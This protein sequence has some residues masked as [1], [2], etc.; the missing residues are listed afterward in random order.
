MVHKKYKYIDTSDTHQP[1]SYTGTA[2]R[3]R[4]AWAAAGFGPARLEVAFALLYKARMAGPECMTAEVYGV[5]V[6]AHT[7]G[8][9]SCSHEY[10]FGVPEVYAWK[11]ADELSVHA[12][13][14]GHRAFA[15]TLMTAV[16]TCDTVPPGDRARIQANLAAHGT[17]LN[18]KISY[19][20]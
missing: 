18:A 4:Y 10:M 16:L 5:G 11:F 17:G 2:D 6:L 14:H 7:H 15:A 20:E 8:S 3:V 12:S 13:H 9:A 19:V 1:F